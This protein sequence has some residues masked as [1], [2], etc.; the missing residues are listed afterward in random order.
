M[1]VDSELA[2]NSAMSEV[3]SGLGYPLSGE[4]AVELYSGLRWR[5]CHR[6]VEED[7][8]LRFDAEKLGRQVDQAIAAKAGAMTAIEG[9]ETFLRGQSHR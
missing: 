8:G 1:I 9:V 3:M 4:Q 2:A 7:S 5:D 6:K